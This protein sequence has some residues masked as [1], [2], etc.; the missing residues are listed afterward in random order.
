[1]TT[2]A[3]TTPFA[4]LTIAA[5]AG[6]ARATLHW[7]LPYVD[8]GSP[9]TG[10]LITPY[11]GGVPGPAVT[12]TS[13]ATSETVTGLANGATYT[14]TAA[15]VNALGV[16]LPT[17]MTA[18][19]TIGVPLPPVSPA[20]VPGANLAIVRWK[21]P[22]NNGAAISAYVVTPYLGAVAMPPRVVHGTSAV[23]TGLGNAKSYSFKIAAINAR[24][25]GGPSTAPAI[26]VGAPGPPTAV[27]AKKVSSG[28][29]RVAFTAP[30]NNGAVIIKYTVV[31][32]SIDGKFSKAKTGPRSPIRFYGLARGKE[33]T[34]SVQATNR[35]GTGPRS[36]PSAVTAA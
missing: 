28:S 21:A 22:A 15:A 14:F 16:G 36:S 20:A 31:C 5:T 30:P 12:Y 13:P 6:N 18:P 9:I 35:R 2:L 17:N 8:G 7:T 19:I 27:V 33:Y 11:L 26:V 1:V 29:I 32:R 4:A 34:C 3:H 24:G 23:I 25:T 10:Y